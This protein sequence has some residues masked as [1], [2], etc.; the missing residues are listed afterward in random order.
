M[1]W[2]AIERHILIFHD[3][4]ISNRRGRFIF[5][6]LPL[7]ILVSY[8]VLLYITTVFLLLCENT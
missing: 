8:I 3:R 2:L 7:I 1:V 5:H 6:Y 4:W